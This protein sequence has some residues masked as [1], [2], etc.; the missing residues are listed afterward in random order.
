MRKVTK[1]G[2]VHCTMTTEDRDIDIKEVHRWHVR[3]GIQSPL[4][5][6]SGY[7]GLIRRDGLLEAGRGSDEIGAHTPGYNDVSI[8]VVLAGGL[9]SDGRPGK[10]FT[11]K[12]LHELSKVIH[13]W[14]LMYPGIKIVGHSDLVKGGKCPSL[15]I[16]GWMNG[17]FNHVK[18]SKGGPDGTSD[19]Q[20]QG[21]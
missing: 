8:S 10:N 2:V 21:G 16:Q 6:L 20:E 1:Y 5:G 12:Q 4:G 17:M 13:Y 14:K 18:A 9:A 3:R 19:R 11:L 7:H 15:D